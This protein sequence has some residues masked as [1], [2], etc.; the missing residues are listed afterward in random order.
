MWQL[1]G[2][3]ATWL[4]AKRRCLVCHTSG[5]DK[6]HFVTAVR[7]NGRLLLD[8]A[9]AQPGAVVAA[10]PGWDNRDL[11][12]H[13]GRVWSFITALVAAGGLERPDVAAPEVPEGDALWPWAD[14]ALNRLVAELAATEPGTPCWTWGPD[15]TTDF[16]ARRMAHET[17]VHRIDAQTAAGQ[18]SAIDSDLAADGVD[19]V[20]FVGMQHSTNPAKEYDYPA[21]S[22]HLHRTDGEGE[23]LVVPNDGSLTVTREHAKGDV[24]VK[25]SG[26][27]LLLYIW[28]RANLDTL[29]IFGDQELAVAWATV[30]P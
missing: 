30:A 29:E 27:E 12:A 16:Y 22:L 11:V 21:G 26:P 19:E 25:G 14:E 9:A 6:D 28:G 4:S 10:C 17:L 13:T 20:L 15:K 1:P 23:W 7:E 2:T 3:V 18:L 5:M 8:A 24:A